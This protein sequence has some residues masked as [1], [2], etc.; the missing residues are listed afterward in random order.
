M[1]TFSRSL[2]I[3]I[4]IMVGITAAFGQT[5][6]YN[7][8][9]SKTQRKAFSLLSPQTKVAIWQEHLAKQLATRSLTQDQRKL[10][11]QGK[12]MVTESLYDG[13]TAAKDFYETDLGKEFKQFQ[14]DIKAN[15]SANEGR[16]VFESLDAGVFSKYLPAGSFSLDDYPLDCNCSTY[17]TF[18]SNGWCGT[19]KGCTHVIDCGPFYGF[20]CDGYCGTG[21]PH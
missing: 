9:E 20:E 7:S 1:K 6:P 19:C 11:V 15:F 18:C 21:C 13:R 8:P 17:W 10:I 3:A 5:C 16:E 14:H 2:A 4:L 12:R